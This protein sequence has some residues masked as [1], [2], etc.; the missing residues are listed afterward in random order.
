MKTIIYA[1]SFFI[2]SMLFIRVLLYLDVIHFKS[3]YLVLEEVRRSIYTIPSRIH[4]SPFR[5]TIEF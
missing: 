4:P 5:I 3:R 1:I 2:L